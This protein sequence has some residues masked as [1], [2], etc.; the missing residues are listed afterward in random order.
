MVTGM[1]VMQGDYEGRPYAVD[2]P[3][4]EDR[5]A[6]SSPGGWHA[7][8]MARMAIRLP[9]YSDESFHC[10]YHGAS[11]TRTS[12]I[13]GI[14]FLLNT[15]ATAIFNR[16]AAGCNLYKSRDLSTPALL[17]AL[18]LL[19]ALLSRSQLQPSTTRSCCALMTS[20]CGKVIL[21]SSST[22]RACSPPR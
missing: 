1:A 8:N 4:M 9:Q 18:L 12:S 17:V 22:R 13:W 15:R 20:A 5:G 14:S 6:L 16:L 21:L 2:V 11:R 10:F 3:V 7:A 19:R